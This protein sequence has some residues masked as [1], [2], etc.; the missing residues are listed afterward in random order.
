[1]TAEPT[2]D[3]TTI[4]YTDGSCIGNPGPGGWGVHVELADGGV[5]EAGGGELRTTNNRMELRAAIE[6]LRLTADAPAVIIVTDSQYVRRG[7][8][9]WL[10]GWR[11][12][13]WRTA[14]G[15]PV[16]NQDLWREVGGLASE[17]VEWRWTRGHAGTPGNERCDEIARAFS[18]GIRRLDESSGGRP[19]AP[20]SAPDAVPGGVRYLSLVDGV[21]ARHASWP[22]CER[23]VRG[24]RGARFKKA[25][26][27]AEER[28]I[29]AEWGLTPEDLFGV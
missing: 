4:A 24:V 22:E 16:E 23:Q 1:M 2:T 27:E 3:G 26:S 8:T 29:V 28:A 6:A 5:V 14:T 21:A 20:A 11:R 7:V 19:P 25:R 15:K 9:A 10:A 17:R 13:G 18:T 12:N